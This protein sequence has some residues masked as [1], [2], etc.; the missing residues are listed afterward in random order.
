MSFNHYYQ[1]ELTALRQL[2]S[3]FA[4]RSPALAPYLGQ[5]GRD[6][7]VER[8]LEGFAFLT[9]R[10]RQKLDD[11]LPELSH[12][13]MHLLWPNYMRPLPAFSMVQF[14]PLARSGPALCVARDTPVTSKPIDGVSCQFRTCYATDVWPLQLNELKYSAKGDGSM[15]SLR[16]AM[17]CEGH[18]GELSMGRLRL[19]LAGERYISQMLY[20]EL[21]RH[22]DTIVVVP[23]D[24]SGQ[25]LAGEGAGVL[26]FTLAPDRVQPVGF[27]EE[28]ALIPYPLNTFRGYR[29]LQEYF[30]FQDKFL[31]V[32]LTGL[33]VLKSLP[34][35][36]LKQV[37]GL[38]LRFD[39]RKSS[40]QRLRP[41]LD[42][43]KLFCTPVVNLF[44][45]DATPIRLD[46]KQDEY[47]VMPSRLGTHNCGVFSVD[48]VNG[49]RVGGAG[50]QAYVPFESF[51][52]DPSFDVSSN[53]AHYSVRQRSS[54][55]HDGL[56]TY[57]S[58]GIRQEHDS[59][60]LSVELTCTNQNLPKQLN[61]GDICLP[62]EGTPEGLLFRN[63]TAVTSSYAPPLTRDFLWKLISNLSLNYLSLANVDALK[64]ILETYDLPRYYDEHAA[65]VS[66]CLL[67]GLKS[68]RHEHVDRLHR[69]LP[70]RGVLTELTIDPQGYVGEGDVFVFASVL[71]E[72][73]ALYASLNSYH[74]LRVNS[75]QGEVYQ[76]TPRMG[77]QPLL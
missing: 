68:I 71:N 5:A 64:V 2:G 9:G 51:E 26:T 58:F 41:T 27:A 29:Y 15:L 43:V 21:L 25:A 54:M 7:D 35:D 17:T 67:D 66:K 46:G 55:L 23:L 63:I 77:L 61:K 65:R 11:E 62:T 60:T 32:D 30:A 74:Q 44:E 57:L 76:W 72:F 52:H 39:I 13:L 20:L 45:H 53:Q 38:E 47:L 42:N 70:L 73:F 37:C 8:L 75:T 34:E 12:S 59:E 10:L 24:A 22:L 1:S 18:L 14:D 48:S 56:D 33:D 4:E 36:T 50:Q 6:P 49:W 19:H 69:G 3:Q 28:E 31:F 40:G 16:L